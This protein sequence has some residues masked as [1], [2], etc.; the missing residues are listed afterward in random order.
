[1][2]DRHSNNN[3]NYDMPNSTVKNSSDAPRNNFTPPIEPL[4]QAPPGYEPEY[5]SPPPAF[6]GQR[7]TISLALDLAGYCNM[8]CR[9]CAE[10]ATQ[11]S[12]R[13]QMTPETMDTAWKFLMPDGPPKSTSGMS[14]RLGTGE[15]LLGFPL[16]K[17]LQELQ[18]KLKEQMKS[19]KSDENSN[20]DNSIPIPVF[21]TTNGTL[22]D[23]ESTDW[24]IKS[25]WNVKISLDGPKSI[26]DRW[27]IL[28]GGIGTFDKISGHVKRFAAEIPDR[29]SVTAV[30]CRGEDPAEAFY[31]I[32]DLGVKRVEMIPACHKSDTISPGPED[33]ERF[34]IFIND[35]ADRLFK[36]D[37]NDLPM[38]VRF[39]GRL[40]R[41]MGYS[42]SR[43]SC[44]AGRGFLGV[45]PKGDLYP[46][47][48][49]VGIEDYRVGSFE[50][51]VDPE[52]ID[53]FQKGA[54][55]P[56][57]ERSACKDCWAAPLCGGP[58]FAVAELFG[59][60]EGE[61]VPIQCQYVRADSTAAFNLYNRLK[62]EK[63][64]RLLDFLPNLMDQFDE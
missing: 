19:E 53:S 10:S 33:V 9:Y 12:S 58:C 4:Y 61:P 44:G 60:G 64:E 23:D 11:P 54:G 36:D 42:L 18:L 2:K 40:I 34:R 5:I 49:F 30:M 6:E 3:S 56:Y 63:P 27:R 20:E 46:C 55:R 35:Y 62:E 32:G 13:P 51:G 48:R 8:A 7:K 28:P 50:S 31:G 41:L 47:F 17:Q 38:L 52:K 43:L 1:M 25:G 21:I 22:L 39:K 29:F 37:N 26:Q 14:I 24:L 57:Q 45:G 15:P 16:M 59:P